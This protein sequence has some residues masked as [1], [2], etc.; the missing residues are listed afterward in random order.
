[1]RIAPIVMKSGL[2]RALLGECFR[3]SFS[4][5]CGVVGQISAT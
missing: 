2:C 5:T 1:M 3:F 4:G